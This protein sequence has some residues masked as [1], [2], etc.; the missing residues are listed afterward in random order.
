MNDGQ[1][2]TDN[3]VDPN[4]PALSACHE[5]GRLLDFWRRATLA[6]ADAV[7]RLQE[8][9]ATCSRTEFEILYRSTEALRARADSAQEQLIIHVGKHGC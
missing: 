6:H 1:N 2:L 7:A 8:T 3:R 9:M 5:K 4:E